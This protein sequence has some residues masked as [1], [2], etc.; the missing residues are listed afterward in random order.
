MAPCDFRRH[1]GGFLLFLALA[2]AGGGP[3][4]AHDAAPGIMRFVVGSA[5]SS[6]KSDQSIPTTQKETCMDSCVYELPT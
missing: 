2:V 3:E 1:L 4:A 5:N 6:W